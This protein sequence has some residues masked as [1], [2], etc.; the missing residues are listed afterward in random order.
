M[1]QVEIDKVDPSTLADI[2][3]IAINHKLPHEDKIL[4][5]IRQ[6]GN[7][8]CFISCGI[9]VRVRFVG[10]GKSLSQSLVSYFSLLKQK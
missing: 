9:P 10:N 8:Y 1:S 3:G 4:S 6:M 5:Y 2:D 7:P